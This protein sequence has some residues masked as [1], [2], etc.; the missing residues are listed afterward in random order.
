MSKPSSLQLLGLRLR[1]AR[2]ARGISQEALALGAGLD[3]SFVG[4][5][6]RGERNIS[7]YSLCKLSAV[8]GT[9]LG[10]LC[11]DLPQAGEKF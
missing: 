6:E 8:V 10:K 7:F 1:E 2:K 9:D 11:Q 4:Q 5:V 3:R